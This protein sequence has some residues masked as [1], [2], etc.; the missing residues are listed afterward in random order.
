[1]GDGGADL[2][3]DA[4]LFDP[5]FKQNAIDLK[6]AYCSSE[7]KKQKRK[8]NLRHIKVSHPPNRDT[9]DFNLFES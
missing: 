6:G 7:N 9:H 2:R 5:T 1:M 3:G 4:N 8:A